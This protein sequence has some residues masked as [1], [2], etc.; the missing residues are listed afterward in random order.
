MPDVHDCMLHI[1]W[2]LPLVKIGL[3]VD[4]FFCH[5]PIDVLLCVGIKPTGGQWSPEASHFFN[6][7]AEKEYYVF[8]KQ[9]SDEGSSIIILINNVQINDK[10]VS[11][12][13]AY[14]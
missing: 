3:P 5:Y 8:C 11:K 6:E 7:F 13:F 1:K 12:G 10:M 4:L 9:L 2:I 14:Q